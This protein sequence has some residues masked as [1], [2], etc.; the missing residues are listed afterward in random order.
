MEIKI[1]TKNK[2]IT[3]EKEVKLVDL[4]TFIMQLDL[5]LTQ[6][7]IVSKKEIVKEYVYM[8][9]QN[10]HSIYTIPYITC[11]YTLNNNTMTFGTK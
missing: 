7:K 10:P 6:W 9:Y 3:L 8:P 11:E 1:D 5:D 2:I 4:I